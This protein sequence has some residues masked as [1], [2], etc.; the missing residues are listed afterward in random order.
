MLSLGGEICG[1]ST[2]MVEV[3]FSLF[4]FIR[5]TLMLKIDR[6]LTLEMCFR[7]TDLS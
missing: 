3:E 5:L 2:P 1:T 4:S 7:S 6:Y